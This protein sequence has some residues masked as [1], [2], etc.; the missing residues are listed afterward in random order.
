MGSGGVEKCPRFQYQGKHPLLY[1]S[2]IDTSIN[3]G[4]SPFKKQ[5]QQAYLRK[6]PRPAPPSAALG[7]LLPAEPKPLV[8]LPLGSWLPSETAGPT[9]SCSEAVWA[10]AWA[11]AWASA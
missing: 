8:L 4:A 11:P 1:S 9:L 5:Q 10:L 7:E 3:Q 2:N 6:A